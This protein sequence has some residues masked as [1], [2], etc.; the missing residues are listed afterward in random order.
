M[1]FHISRISRDRY[2]FDLGLFSYN[3]NAILANFHAARVF[4]RKINE[5]RDLVAFPESSVQAGQI[6]AMGLI[7][8]ILHHVVELYRRERN[9]EILKLALKRL[10]TKFTHSRVDSMLLQ[11]IQ[12]F[13]PLAVY[14]N[15]T[16]ARQYLK[17]SNQGVPN[18]E[19]VLEEMILLRVN[20]ENPALLPY[21][22]L[23]SDKNLAADPVYLPAIRELELFFEVQP[24]FGPDNQTLLEMLRAPAKA[25]PNSLEDQLEFIRIR[26]AALLGE[27]LFRLLS[28]L[29]LIKEEHKMAA[30]GP[31]PVQIPVYPLKHL[32]GLESEEER[33]SA[34]REWMPRLVLLAKNTY[35]WLHQ[36]S[37]KYQR[38]ITRLDQIPDEELDRMAASGFTG[39]W[40]IGL[41]ERS[42]ASARIK[43]MCGNPD[44]IASAYS[45]FDYRIADPLGGEDAFENLKQRASSRGI[46]L[47]SDMVPNHMGIDSPWVMDHPDW[48]LSL[49]YLPFPSHSFNGANLSSNPSVGIYLEDH[50]FDRTDAAV[51]FKRVDYPSGDTR[52]IYHGNDGTSMPWN[53]T[54]Q[55]DY[56]NPAVRE[57]V[58]QTI[59]AVAR[60]FPIIRFDAAMTLAKKHFQRL[61]F[62]EPGTG[63]AI[64][65]RA[66]FSMTKDQFNEHMPVEFWREVVDRASAEAPDTLLLAEAFWLMEGYFVRTLGMHRVYN[67]AFMHMLRNEDNAGYRQL[68]KNTLEFDPEI[69]KRYVNFMNNP[70]ER[71]AV[72]QFGKGDK[73]FGI[74]TLMATLPGLPMF[75][76]GQVEGFA[77]KYGMEFTKPLWEEFEDLDLIERHKRLIFPLLH[78]REL[79]AGVEYFQLFDLFTSSGSVD[80]NVFAFSNR[81][82]GRSALVIYHNKFTHTSGWLKISCAKAIRTAGEKRPLTQRNLAEALGITPTANAFTI[83]RDQTSG[84][85]F[86]RS[87]AEL[88]EN[89]LNVNLNA[90]ECQVLL[91]FRQVQD[92]PWRSYSQL[93][94]TLGGRGVP[95]IDLALKEM[96][97]Q[98]VLLPFQEL[99]NK[100]YFEYLIA[101]RLTKDNRRIKPSLVQEFQEKMQRLLAGA[102]EINNGTGFNQNALGAANKQLETVLSL[103]VIDSRFPLPPGARYQKSFSV[104]ASPLLEDENTWLSLFAWSFLTPLGLLADNAKAPEQ[105]VAWMDEWQLSHRLQQ[106]TENLGRDAYQ[107]NR[108]LLL[109]RILILQQNWFNQPLPPLRILMQ[110][111]LAVPEIRQ[112]LGVNRYQ[113][114]LWF[115]KEAF[116]EF[117]WWMYT[118]ALIS[119]SGEPGVTST[120]ILEM[121][122]KLSVLDRQMKNA[123]KK[124]KFQIERMMEALK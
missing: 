51:E 73:Y 68:I 4:A 7:D 55:L 96:N 101:N 81:F 42:H 40:L 45:L 44:A 104:F 33:F 97:F 23:F 11:F 86:I 99:A 80:E 110:S 17:G 58:I 38:E 103:L 37:R 77:E 30:F 36:L 9:P 70:D 22:E 118:L 48:F 84:L 59:L 10:D 82:Q 41:W 8:E 95:D 93:C 119:T 92:D 54:A 18:R 113:E 88:Y 25:N 2:Q 43:Q 20:N 56:L 89:G 62:P 90:Y 1:E 28:S 63:G 67:S 114:V 27:Y 105:V 102:A 108:I 74:C 106:A 117:L 69:L 32:A 3:G 66:D 5:H 78:Q 122:I 52:Y 61:W 15:E 87:S 14:R 71:T 123:L 79:F 121:T 116:E 72:D 50:Y 94:Q 26:W 115:N 120:E 34:D 75:G 47:A 29:D 83:F 53:D 109:T 100:G 31:G 24:H 60:R 19:S 39:L 16:T 35:V 49:N 111:W 12:E 13:P 21:D 65:T 76:H 98:A 85:Q 64:P 107:V 6:N 46:R 112:F 124:S 57:A 91:D